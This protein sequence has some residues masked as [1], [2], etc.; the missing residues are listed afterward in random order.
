MAIRELG[1]AL[2]ASVCVV[3]LAT[4]AQAQARSFD[5]P[6]G[7]LKAALDAYSRQAGQPIIY[8][9]DEVRSARSRGFRG[10]ATPQA[11]LI[12]LLDGSGFKAGTDNS[13][14]IAVYR[15]GN[16][17]SGVDQRGGPDV[18]T[19]SSAGE[20]HSQNPR[21]DGAGEEIIVTA[22]KREQRLIDTPQ[23]ITVVTAADLTRQGATQF[24][25]FAGTIPGLSF[26]TTGAGYTQVALRGVTLG[27]EVNSTVGIYV[28]EVPYGSSTALAQGAQIALDVGLFDLD[29]IE[30]LRG[31][32][33][34]LYGA[35]SMGGLIKYVPKRP[36][37]SAFFADVQAGLSATH[38]GGLNYNGAVALNLPIATD[39]AA[40]RATGF[41]SRDGGF[42][43]NLR[44]GRD[45]VDRSRVYGGRL[46]IL[47]NPTPDLTLRLGGFLQNIDR[48]D[49]ATADYDMSGRP[50]DGSLEQ[51]RTVAEA[52]NQEFRLVSGTAIYD[53]G[54]VTLTSISSYQT[55]KTRLVFDF[56]GSGIADYVASLGRAFSAIALPQE[57]RIKKFTQEVRL[58]SDGRGPV[59]WLLGGFYTHE[60]SANFQTLDIRDP[61][62]L[63]MVNDIFELSAP[64]RYK[65]VAL[66]G[67]LTWHLTP[68]LE[69]TGGL[70]YARNHQA[71]TQFGSGAFVSNQPTTR[72]R[73]SV[74]TYL[75]NARYAFTPNASAYL[76]Y[77]TGY[78]PGGPNFSANDPDTGQP[79]FAPF[80]SDKLKSYEIG[81]KGE[82][83]DRKFGI[84]M[85]AYYIDWS[86]LQIGIFR[87]GLSGIGNA[88]RTGA[89]VRGAELSVSARPVRGFTAS[90]AFAYQ[91]AHLSD[92]DPDL[93][94]V[95]GERLPTVPR[96]TASLNADYVLLDQPLRPSFGAGL[97]YVSDRPLTLQSQGN[98]RLPDY[99]TIDLRAGFRLA[100]VDVHFFVRNLLDRRGQLNAQLFR[101]PGAVQV[102]VTQ[103]RTIGISATTSF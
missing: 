19:S 83:V 43:D 77:A 1:A 84:D 5:V 79:L 6:A 20:D 18:P 98:Y 76:R 7:N 87:G 88:T 44:T 10:S 103:P 71:Y 49:A 73:E 46:D 68:K 54:P 40:V 45:D 70:R 3:A 82:T 29:R 91:D 64:S 30:V 32:Q 14:A 78:R 61:S 12:T 96:F 81:F 13:G 28:D 42:I 92:D 89:T 36:D 100:P 63:P 90:G 31:P 97:R 95:K 85:A 8:K 80:K 47:L 35:S 41:Y 37:A 53:F 15:G 48:D 22:Q 75:A 26:T 52:F 34:T 56:T 101:S 21:T 102:A 59:E 23:A 33:G 38:H 24:R 55:M 94:A 4:P 66:F 69:V 65:E 67:D 25:D 72:S 17:Q 51:R 60:R 58:A 57:L 62:G 50:I 27:S 11:A 9:A 2:A 86:D 93:G 99:V 39:Q 16:A 74:F